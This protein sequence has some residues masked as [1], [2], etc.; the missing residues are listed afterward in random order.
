MPLRGVGDGG[1]FT[2]LADLR[3]F[4]ATLLAGRIVPPE[5]SPMTLPRSDP[6]DDDRR[7]GLGSWLPA[8]GDAIQL[9]G[10]DAGISPLDLPAV[11]GR[12]HTMI[13]NWTEASGRSS[14]SSARPIPGPERA[15]DGGAAL[16]RACAPD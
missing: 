4:W 2:T 1:L 10:Y 6:P 3:S 11:D 13:S 9:E 14:A 16:R 5:S 8:G 7:Y 15:S 12:G